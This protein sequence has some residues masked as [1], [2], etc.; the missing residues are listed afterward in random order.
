MYR[1]AQYARFISKVSPKLSNPPLSPQNQKGSRV[2][3]ANGMALFLSWLVGR[4]MAQLYMFGHL[5]QHQGEISLLTP[6]GQ[7]LIIGVP[8][9]LFSLNM[10]YVN[11]VQSRWRV[12]DDMGLR[13]R[14]HSSSCNVYSRWT[15]LW[16]DHVACSY[17]RFTS[18]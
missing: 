7:A 13:P 2:Y 1:G 11:P 12:P 3:L 9:I 4:I 18:V 8:P 10:W 5:Y 17:C 6:A 16:H 15:V 14:M